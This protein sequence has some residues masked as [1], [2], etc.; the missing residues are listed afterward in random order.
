MNPRDEAQRANIEIRTD[1]VFETTGD[2]INPLEHSIGWYWRILLDGTNILS[3]GS[4]DPVS[5]TKEEARDNALECFSEYLKELQ[6]KVNCLAND[7][8]WWN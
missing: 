1:E 6:L 3:S 2:A 5:K 4:K 7:L 8:N